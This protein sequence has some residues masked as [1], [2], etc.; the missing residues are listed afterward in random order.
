MDTHGKCNIP[1]RIQILPESK[2]RMREVVKRWKNE[3]KKVRFSFS[4]EG[5]I[6]GTEPGGW[7]VIE[8]DAADIRL[9]T[10]YKRGTLTQK[11]TLRAMEALLYWTNYNQYPASSELL[12][13]YHQALMEDTDI[14]R[15]DPVSGHRVLVTTSS[16]MCTTVDMNNFIDTAIHWL[17]MADIPPNMIEPI[18]EKDFKGIYHEWYKARS[19]DPSSIDNIKNWEEYCER[20]PYDEFLCVGINEKGTGQTQKIHIVSRGA[21]ISAVDEPW[22]WIR[23]ATSIHDKIHN[24]N[25]GWTAVLHEFPHVAPK[26]HRARELAKKKELI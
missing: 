1:R 6:I 24:S 12:K 14:K 5:H 23:G 13:G 15:E 7:L 2:D 20:F 19:V 21:D 17:L 26:V 16:P 10:W 11:A 22:N 8:G 25:L 3:G 9:E 18:S 4:G